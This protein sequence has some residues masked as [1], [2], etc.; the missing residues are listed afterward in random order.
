MIDPRYIVTVAL[1]LATPAVA[2]TTPSPIEGPGPL[3]K[4]F[5]CDA[6]KK[7]DDGSW[8]PT[9][10]VNIELPD[11]TVITLGPAASFTPGNATPNRDVGAVIE[12][13]CR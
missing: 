6:F 13:E 12:R 7:E 11:R 2:E 8:R 3:S 1:F 9:R 10:D 5:P 4:H